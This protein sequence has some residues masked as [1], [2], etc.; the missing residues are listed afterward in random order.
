MADF[1]A[2]PPEVNSARMYAGPRAAPLRAAAAAWN[3]VA[4]QLG[5]TA[6]AYQTV[7]ADLTR[8][9]QGPSAASMT[10]AAAPYV[11]WLSETS[12]QAQQSAAQATTAAAAYES[13]FAATVPP[14]VI[15][16]N[17]A[18][19]MLLIATNVLGQNTPAIAAAEAAYAEM[20]AQ[21]ATAMYGYAGA[22]SAA[23]ALTPFSQP[24]QTTG[25]A[26]QTGQSVA[27]AQAIGSSS[28]GEALTPLLTAFSDFNT[29]AG[30]LTPTWQWTYSAF[31]LGN[32]VYAAKSDFEAHNP[33]AGGKETPQLVA[34]GPAT[35]PDGIGQRGPVLAGTGRAAVV[36]KLS[37]PH[38]WVSATPATTTAVEVPPA[39]GSGLRALPAW[40][41][42]SATTAGGP[43]PSSVGPVRGVTARGAQKK[44]LA[45]R[46]RRFRMPR[47]T[48][49]G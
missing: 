34:T 43:A 41:D 37:V 4:E 36:G 1:G 9:W 42:P 13:A 28:G 23:S 2:L 44:V 5:A 35:P 3:A 25:P 30:P 21:D 12:A 22:A 27:V 20:W 46:D 49:G 16:A 38:I 33:V 19:L 39:A 26:G 7:T 24:P 8:S 10:A 48:A 14:A 45:M 17:R 32:L 6:G 47:P 18:L 15:E 40:A 31:Q 11:A 29:L